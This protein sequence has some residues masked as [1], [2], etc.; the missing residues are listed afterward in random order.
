MQNA[1]AAAPSSSPADTPTTPTG[2]AAS[3]R[4]SGSE[5]LSPDWWEVPDG[6]TVEEET[7]NYVV[8]ERSDVVDALASFVAACIVSLPESRSM[9]PKQLQ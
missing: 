9:E 5:V 2:T 7:G 1:V 4:L 6:A 8:I 3:Q